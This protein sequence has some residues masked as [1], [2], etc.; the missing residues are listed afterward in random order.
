MDYALLRKEHATGI[1]AILTDS[2]KAKNFERTLT[3]PAILSNA[4]PICEMVKE[5]GRKKLALVLDYHLS[6]LV[7]LLNLNLTLN[8]VQLGVIVEDLLDRYP[9]ETIEDF[10]LIFKKARQGEYGELFRVDSAI[11]FKW[12]EKYLQEKYQA[13]EDK[14]QR[15]KNKSTSGPSHEIKQEFL[16]EWTQAIDGATGPQAVPP[17]SA[18]HIADE[19]KQEPKPKQASSF[20]YDADAAAVSLEGHHERLW[21]AQELTV[22]QCHPEFNEEQIQARCAELKNQILDAENSVRFSTPKVQKI[23]EDYMKAKQ[24]RTSK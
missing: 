22:R 11:V 1:V 14:L 17:L 9:Q 19:G 15:E 3:I 8:D 24:K 16:D 20:V 4:L 7:S 21:K 13:M 10:I 12:V 18:D 23:W 2:E 5:V 6:R